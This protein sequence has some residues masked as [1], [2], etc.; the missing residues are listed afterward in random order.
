MVAKFEPTTKAN[1]IKVKREL[2]KCKLYLVLHDPDHWILDL[3]LIWI[4][5]RCKHTMF[6]REMI[7]H[8][9]HNLP[10]EYQMI[11]LLF[12][13]DL[14]NEFATLDSMKVKLRTKF[15]RSSAK[16]G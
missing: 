12:E 13:N 7:H 16:L 9:L 5:G 1:L 11:L 14:E 15:E 3:E 6:E 2:V 10:V 4:R 8:I